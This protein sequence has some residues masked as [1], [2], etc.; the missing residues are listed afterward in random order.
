MM[1]DTWLPLLN[2][3]KNEYILYF[4]DIDVEPRAYEHWKEQGAAPVIPAY[5]AVNK[6]GTKLIAH[7]SGYKNRTDFVKWLNSEVDKFNNDVQP[8]PE[9]PAPPPPLPPWSGD[10]G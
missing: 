6:G 1:K 9:P 3:I 5:T 8:R 2:I 4:V 10:G 7:G